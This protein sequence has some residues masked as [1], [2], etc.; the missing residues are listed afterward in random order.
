MNKDSVGDRVL[1]VLIYICLALVLIIMLYP[2]LF[3]LS[4]SIS[5]PEF[6]V[7][8]KMW[9]FPL[10]IT[11]Q[12]YSKIFHNREILISYRNTILYTGLGTIISLIMTICAAYP[13]SRRDFTGR[14]IITAIIVFTM[15]FSGGLIPTFLLIKKLHMM[16]TIWAIILPGAAS[17]WNIIIM[18][19]F[20]QTGI[21]SEVQESA[22]I[23]GCS[24]I[25]ILLRI[26][27]PLSMPII[28]VM[29]LF[30]SVGYWNSYFNAL[31]YLSDRIKYPLQLILREI[32]VQENM[33]DMQPSTDSMK[34]IFE[35][36]ALK[37]TVIVVANLP[38]MMLYP[39][40]QKYFARGMLVGAIKG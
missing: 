37:Y 17:V 31:I 27:L 36:E 34:I 24:N 20:F 25:Q 8:G 15:F 12:G 3:V 14:G 32:L 22:S 18:R 10:D 7:S 38:I 35:K 33:S 9:L 1:G 19:T 13:L 11:F 2:L 28:A 29:V 21:P 30:Y 4:A 23:D 39:L 5:N 16:N 40:L 6:V 26:V